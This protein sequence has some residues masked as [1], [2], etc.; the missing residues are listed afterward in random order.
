M[1]KNIG[2][3][4]G[5]DP[6]GVILLVAAFALL[7]YVATLL[8]IPYFVRSINVN[9][10]KKKAKKKADKLDPNQNVVDRIVKYVEDNIEKCPSHNYMY[11]WADFTLNR[12]SI[13]DANV[14]DLIHDDYDVRKIARKALKMRYVCRVRY[15]T[16]LAS[17]SAIINALKKKGYK[18]DSIDKNRDSMELF[19]FSIYYEGPFFIYG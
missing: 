3:M 2:L 15:V 14:L 16:I 7:V 19:P 18:V 10:V 12:T 9:L 1:L 8:I 5:E 13:F 6:A 11:G 17:R 4:W